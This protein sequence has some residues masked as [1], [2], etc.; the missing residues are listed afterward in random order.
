MLRAS[1]GGLTWPAWVIRA[2]NGLSSEA[3]I[4]ARPR[5]N[6]QVW[7]WA[8]GTKAEATKANRATERKVKCCFHIPPPPG[9]LKG[10]GMG[11]GA[12]PR[13]RRCNNRWRLDTGRSLDPARVS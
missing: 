5:V 8:A 13:G 3:C 7:E 10:E 12:L 1:E 4:V 2:L 6:S 9:W 11:Q